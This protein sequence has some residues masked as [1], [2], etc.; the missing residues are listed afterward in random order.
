MLGFSRSPTQPYTLG[1][2]NCGPR[3]LCDQLNLKSNDDDPDFGKDDHTFARRSTVRFI[4][5][6]IATK[7]MDACFLTPS[8]T[9]YMNEM[10]SDGTFVDNIFIQ[11][12]A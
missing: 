3:A 4:K 11:V 8:P 5:K 2:G 6:Q 12:F 9:V 1:D 10:A 7:K